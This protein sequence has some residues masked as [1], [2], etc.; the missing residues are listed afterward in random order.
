[1]LYTFEMTEETLDRVDDYLTRCYVDRPDQFIMAVQRLLWADRIVV[2]IECDEIA[3]TIITLMCS[4][5]HPR[6][7]M[8]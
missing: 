5:D 6:V 8:P 4:H 7:G 2:V 3:A 1:M